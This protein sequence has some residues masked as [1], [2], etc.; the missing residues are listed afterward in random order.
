MHRHVYSFIVMI[1]AAILIAACGSGDKGPAE[2]ALK[3]AEAA[4]RSGNRLGQLAEADLALAEDPKNVRARY[5]FADALI[6]GGDVEAG[7]T[8]LRA[9][10][11]NPLAL[12]RAKAA[13][14]P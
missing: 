3:A 13:S 10:G 7:C 11:R 14:C 9:L 8:Y 12:A 6:K 2:T 5:L 4:L 1:L